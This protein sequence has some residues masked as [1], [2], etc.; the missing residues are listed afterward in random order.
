MSVRPGTEGAAG[1]TG[2]VGTLGAAG[3]EELAVEAITDRL[4]EHTLASAALGRPTRVRVLVPAGFDPAQRTELPVLW[5]LHGGMDDVT[6]WTERG[7]AEALTAGLDLIVVM[8]DA[9]V[10]GFG[11]SA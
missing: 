6:S 3:I 2:G 4:T 7:H 8:P 1:E 9:G 10:G 11:L 5:L